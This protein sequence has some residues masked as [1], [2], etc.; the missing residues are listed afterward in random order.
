MAK[1]KPLFCPRD[2]T[3]MEKATRKGVT[4]D[5]CR[6]CGGMWLDKGENDKLNKKVKSKK[7]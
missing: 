5:I 3:L 2:L 1:D 6:K 4:I 7:W